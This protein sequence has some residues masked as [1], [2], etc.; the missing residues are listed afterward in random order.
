[1]R[2]ALCASAARDLK[3]LMRIVSRTDA[4]PARRWR[5]GTAKSLEN[6]RLLRIYW[7]RL[8]VS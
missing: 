5:T 1:M 4:V 3:T 8:M 7:I 2:G 6:L